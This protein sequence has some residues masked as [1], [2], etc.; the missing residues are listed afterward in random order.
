MDRQSRIIRYM[1]LSLLL[2][3]SSVVATA[4]A[5]RVVVT[6]GEGGGPSRGPSRKK[7]GTVL[8]M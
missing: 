2:L 7:I 8:L 6:S 1:L 5:E 4:T 3:A